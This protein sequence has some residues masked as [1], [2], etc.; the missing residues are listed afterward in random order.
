[1]KPLLTSIA[2]LGL[3]GCVHAEAVYAN[4]DSQ[5]PYGVVMMGPN[6]G[7]LIDARTESCLL[8]YQ[9]TA[10]A[11]VSCAMLKKNVPESARYITWNVGTGADSTATPRE[12]STPPPSCSSSN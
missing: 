8:V 5:A 10:A 1:M 3:V 11:Q 7:Y 6:I 4:L 2:L 9:N 12:A